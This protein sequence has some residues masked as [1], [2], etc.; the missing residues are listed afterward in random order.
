MNDLVITLGSA[1]VVLL[2]IGVVA[3]LGFR[4]TARLDDAWM[5]DLAAAEGA[6]VEGA[7]VSPDGRAALAR[8]GAGKLMVARVMGN[9]VSTRVAPASAARVRLEGGKL[10]VQFGDL[11]YPPLHMRVEAAP[12]WLAELA[13]GD[14]P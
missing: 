9:D 7:V 4:Q 8:L 13:A 5:R 14:R 12:P 3:A 11:G 10:S 1:T 2:M 6:Q